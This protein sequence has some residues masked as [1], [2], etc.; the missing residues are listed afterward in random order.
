MSVAERLELPAER[1]GATERLEALLDPGSLQ[2]I[3]SL[4][5]SPASRAPLAGDGLVAA[6][7]TVGGHPVFCYS[8]DVSFAG[9]SLGAA[10]AETIVGLLRLAGR[11]GAPLVGFI[12]SAGARLD[13]GIAALGGYAR[14]FREMVALSGRVPQI[15]VVSGV[16]AG[17]G[18]YATALTDFVVMTEASAMFLTGPAVVREVTGEAASPA[19]LG[20]PAVHTRNGVCQFVAPSERDAAALVRDLLALLPRRTGEFPEATTPLEPVETDPAAHVPTASRRVYDVRSVAR[21]LVDGGWLLEVNER[22]ARN[23]VTA[24]C[25]IDGRPAGVV[26]NQ[27]W[28]LG[29]VLEP[30]AAQKGARFVRTCNA[31]GLPVIVLVD[32]PGFLPGS[33]P[34]SQGIIRH[35]AKLVYAFAEAEVPKITVILRKAYGGGYIAM[36]S[37]DLGADLTLAWPGAEIGIMGAVQAVRVIHRRRL[38]A[39]PDPDGLQAELATA[40]A[41][42]NLHAAAAARAGYVDEVIAPLDTRSRIVTAL[43]ALA[44]GPRS[45]GRAIGNIPL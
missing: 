44:A 17:G 18:A 4:R 45:A 7:G 6:M 13:D 15:S 42:E 36:C 9:G 28:H 26:A 12:D 14:I 3:R 5:C 22:W 19:G 1:I 41:A 21:A 25:R 30:A 43:R 27:P 39:A 40:Y 35:G 29:G 8:H 31:F 2:T 34:E 10:G 11:A 23:L 20:G 33:G 32:T 38:A 16:G 37:R 24:F